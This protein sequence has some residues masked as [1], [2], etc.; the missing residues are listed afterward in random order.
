MYVTVLSFLC[1]YLCIFLSTLHYL[2]FYDFLNEGILVLNSIPFSCFGFS[3]QF[4]LR[5]YWYEEHRIML[6]HHETVV[7]M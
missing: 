4:L 5:L 7:Q 6:R 2:F 1:I 3:C